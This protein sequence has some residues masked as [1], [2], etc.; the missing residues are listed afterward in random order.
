MEDQEVETTEGK[1]D[2]GILGFGINWGHTTSIEVAA[3]TVED[4]A[5]DAKMPAMIM[6]PTYF[7]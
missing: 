7:G 4:N 6:S 1:G 5:D 3:W 2:D